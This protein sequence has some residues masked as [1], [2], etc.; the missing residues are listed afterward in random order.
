MVRRKQPGRNHSRIMNKKLH[1]PHPSSIQLSERPYPY[2]HTHTHTSIT[3]HAPIC[4]AHV[5]TLQFFTLQVF[6]LHIMF[7]YIRMLMIHT[8]TYIP[9][10]AAALT[11]SFT[12]HFTTLADTNAISLAS[13]SQHS[14]ANRKR[15]LNH[16]HTHCSTRVS[17]RRDSERKTNTEVRVRICKE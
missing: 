15:N 7:A 5:H 11:S 13:T 16:T 10:L 9:K 8:H 14:Q 17:D 3:L 12:H 6:R 2:T 4:T 1:L